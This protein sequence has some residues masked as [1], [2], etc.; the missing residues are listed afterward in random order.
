MGW[1]VR[2]IASLKELGGKAL[3]LSWV[4][5][6]FFNIHFAFHFSIWAS[7]FYIIGSGFQFTIVAIV[8]FGIL[9]SDSRGPPSALCTL[10]LERWGWL[11]EKHLWRSG[12]R[13][14][15]GQVRDGSQ[16]H[17]HGQVVCVVKV[18]KLR[19]NYFVNLVI[20]IIKILWFPTDLWY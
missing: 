3:G 12:A 11:V 9:T 4:I 19:N 7:L 15:D 2:I 10:F 18:K 5:L 16:D 8:I 13:S 20:S 14:I 6:G 1:G 17:S